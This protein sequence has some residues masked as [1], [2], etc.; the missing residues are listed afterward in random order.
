MF[1]QLAM[2]EACNYIEVKLATKVL[3]LQL[4]FISLRLPFMVVVIALIGLWFYMAV[5]QE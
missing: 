2:R 5:L 4:P 1:C 3:S